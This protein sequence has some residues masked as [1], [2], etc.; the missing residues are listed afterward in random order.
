MRGFTDPAAQ[1]SNQASAQIEVAVAAAVSAIRRSPRRLSQL[2]GASR[3][4]I[5][6]SR[7]VH[8]VCE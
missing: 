7:P 4:M 2:V 3:V 8:A 1:T 6:I 5:A